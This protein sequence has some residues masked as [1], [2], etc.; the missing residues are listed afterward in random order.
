[1]IDGNGQECVSFS[2]D[3]KDDENIGACLQ[4]VKFN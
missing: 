2:I 1:M 4:I 3:E